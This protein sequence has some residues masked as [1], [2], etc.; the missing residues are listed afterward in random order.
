MNLLFTIVAAFP[1]GLVLTRRKTAVLAYL[2]AA[3][4]VFSFQSI[5]VLL[6]WM[7]GG[8][9][10]GGA[11]GFGKPPSGNFPVHYSDSELAAYGVV[12]LAITLAGVGLVTLGAK[13]R[14]RRSSRQELVDVGPS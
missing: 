4:F 7:S 14:A 13:L 5:G 6:T 2:I 10:I 11:S 8:K 9:G 3:S 1:L 12:N